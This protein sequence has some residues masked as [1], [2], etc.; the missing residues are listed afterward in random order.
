M[1]WAGHK[2]LG[3]QPT[4]KPPGL[5]KWLS[6]L[7]VPGFPLRSCVSLKRAALGMDQWVS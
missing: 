4:G 1:A 5:Q 2:Q 3:C 6:Y 7:S